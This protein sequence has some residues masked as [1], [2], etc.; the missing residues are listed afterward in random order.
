VTLNSNGLAIS[1]AA[2]GGGFTRSRFNPFMEA[3]AVATQFGQGSLHIHPIPDPEAFQFDRMLFD[4]QGTQATNSNSSGSITISM[5]AG[6][7]TRNVSTLSLVAS[8]STSNALSIS[9]TVRS[10]LN[11]GARVLSMGWT[12]TIA[13]NDLWLGIVSRTTSAGANIYTLSQYAASDINSDFSGLFG[14]ANN[15]SNQNVLGLGT[16]SASTS[17]IPGSI[18]FSDI[19]GTASGVLRVPMY[20]F[21]SQTA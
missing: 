10:S 16:Y 18:A 11:N 17:G 14:V 12:T 8:A 21:V 13:Q 20:Y 4:V 19:R 9:G 6:L 7:Y 1:V 2:A 5:W 3:V 15:A